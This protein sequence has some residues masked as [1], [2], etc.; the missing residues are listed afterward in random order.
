VSARLVTGLSGRVSVTVVL[1]LVTQQLVEVDETDE[2][3]V[4]K[5]SPRLAELWEK[6]NAPAHGRRAGTA[7]GI[8]EGMSGGRKDR[9]AGLA[10]MIR[11][12]G[13]LRLDGRPLSFS[14]P[15]RGADRASRS[16]KNRG[17]L[18]WF[19]EAELTPTWRSRCPK[20]TIA[21][22]RIRTLT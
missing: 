17:I 22:T 11:N 10:D 19:H 4:Y 5:L 9:R 12:L 7:E 1:Q 13:P 8:S 20:S 16:Q 6:T 21:I 3:T 2:G 18:P 15:K 14:A